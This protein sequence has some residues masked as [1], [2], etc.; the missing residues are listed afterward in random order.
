MLNVL[1]ATHNDLCEP[2]SEG[3]IDQLL[4]EFAEAEEYSRRIERCENCGTTDMVELEDSR[5]CYTHGTID[6]GPEDPNR[7]VALCRDCAK[8]HHDNWD[9]MWSD[10]YGS[11]L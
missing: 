4:G 9:A 2:L 11:R 3:D 10:Y 1:S 5:T 6:D 7:R 8:E